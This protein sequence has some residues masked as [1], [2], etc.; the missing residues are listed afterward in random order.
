VTPTVTA[1][2]NF[3]VTGTDLGANSFSGK[4]A[5]C[6]GLSIT[7]NAGDLVRGSATFKVSHD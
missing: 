6:T 5:I 2:A 1:T 4:P 3:T 7:G